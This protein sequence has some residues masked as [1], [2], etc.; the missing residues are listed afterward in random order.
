MGP[1]YERPYRAMHRL[2]ES[3]LRRR[4]GRPSRL[5]RELV[6]AAALELLGDE[7]TDQ[8]SIAK[9]GKQIWLDQ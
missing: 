7:R 1:G 6:L 5:S 3:A 8:F 2:P 9:L 4:A